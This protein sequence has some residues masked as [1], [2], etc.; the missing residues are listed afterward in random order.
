MT[1]AITGS[2]GVANTGA[3]ILFA[4]ANKRVF[5]FAFM[6]ARI[7][8]AANLASAACCFYPTFSSRTLFTPDFFLVSYLKNR[9]LPLRGKVPTPIS[10]IEI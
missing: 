6:C 2:I 3:T 8:N 5:S 9:T 4:A 10:L 1:D 7:V